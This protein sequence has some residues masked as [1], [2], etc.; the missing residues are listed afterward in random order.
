M[1]SASSRPL[2]VPRAVPPPPARRL[3]TPDWSQLLVTEARFIAGPDY[4]ADDVERERA[5]RN[6]FSKMM[7]IGGRKIVDYCLEVVADAQAPRFRRRLAL[8]VAKKHMAVGDAARVRDTAQSLRTQLAPVPA[9]ASDG[10][11]QD[12]STP[13]QN[14]IEAVQNPSDA[15][16]NPSDAVQDPSDAVQDRLFKVSTASSVVAAMRGRFRRCYQDALNRDRY[17]AGSITLIAF[18]RADGSVKDVGAH[19]TD[20][21]PHMTMCLR[22]VVA[23]GDFAPPTGGGATVT[24]PITFVRQ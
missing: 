11:L 5:L 16:Q 8:D 18:I 19:T 13:V 3:P 24:I 21:G 4:D 2:A 1:P 23:E 12:P 6:T 9:P 10:P 17:L 15:V 20:F 14:P 7:N 22:I